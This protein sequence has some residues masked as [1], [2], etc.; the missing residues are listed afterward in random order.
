MTSRNRWLLPEDGI[1]DEIAIEVATR[2]ARPVALTPAE[3]RLAAGH[4][5]ARGGTPFQ[6][7]RRLRISYTAACALAADLAAEGRRGA[8]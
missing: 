2:G 6:I 1:V 7:C 3:R 5:L 8:A 4:I